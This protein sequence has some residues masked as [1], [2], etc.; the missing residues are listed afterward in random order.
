MLKFEDCLAAIDTEINKR[1]SRWTLTAVPHFDFEDA[2]QIIRIHIHRKWAQY[3]QTKPLA[4]WVNAV[5][6]A[7][8]KNIVRNIYSNFCR[9]CLKC[10]AALEPGGCEVYEEQCSRCPLY[11]NWEK[12]KKRAYNTKLPLP[13]ENHAHEIYNKECG[14]IDIEKAIG[15]F[16][17]AMF[18]KLKNKPTELKLYEILYVEN[19]TEKEAAGLMGYKTNELNRYPGYRQIKN[20]KKD[21]LKKAKELLRDE[22]VDIF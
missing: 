15:K 21:I 17:K 11:A 3:D 2:A 13:L 1:R 9:P 8:L 12:G 19:K 16:H 20:I 18:E 4:P 10:P 22:E 14:S 6:S 7:Q 5:I